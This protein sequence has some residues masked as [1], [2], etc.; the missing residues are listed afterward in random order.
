MEQTLTVTQARRELLDLSKKFAR[1]K[2]RQAISVTRRGKPVLALVPWEL[3]D[4]LLETLEIMS[5]HRLMERLAQSI[6]EAGTGKTIPL[7]K[8][9]KK[10]NA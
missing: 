10:L 1:G 9:R 4:S 6:R 3:Y 7:D 8:L 2:L 5:D